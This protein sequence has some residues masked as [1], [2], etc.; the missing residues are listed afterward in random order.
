MLLLNTCLSAADVKVMFGLQE[1]LKKNRKLGM[2]EKEI[3]LKASP[4]LKAIVKCFPG[5]RKVELSQVVLVLENKVPSLVI[6]CIF[7]Q[8]ILVPYT[9]C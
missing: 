8:G 2:S 1:E 7:V 4:L 5:S 6:Y 9:D 3:R